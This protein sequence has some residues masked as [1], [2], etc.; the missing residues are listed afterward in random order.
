M[1]SDWRPMSEFDR[2]EARQITLG[3]VIATLY[4]REGHLVVE[5]T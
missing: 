5:E 1:A 3:D 2:Q 4:A